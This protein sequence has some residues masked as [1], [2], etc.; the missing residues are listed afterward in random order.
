MWSCTPAPKHVAVQLH[1]TVT[2]SLVDVS[3][4]GHGR[5]GD[6]LQF[7]NSKELLRQ[8]LKCCKA[9]CT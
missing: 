1:V 6:V 7:C 2:V 5:S 4:G 8:H 3:E 9:K